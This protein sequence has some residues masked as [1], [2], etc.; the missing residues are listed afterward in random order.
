MA[1]QSG[2]PPGSSVRLALALVVPV[3]DRT[4]D[5][6]LGR[7]RP[8]GVDDVAHDAGDVVGRATAQGEVDEGVDG[9]L[10]IGNLQRVADGVLADD[11]GK[12]V[13][14]KQIPVALTDFTDRQVG[15]VV[16]PA[17]QNAENH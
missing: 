14:A 17:I 2:G 1:T 12:P 10:R 7:R 13:A 5:D 15:F 9:L 8:A 3:G 6:G 4:T 11:A 16:G